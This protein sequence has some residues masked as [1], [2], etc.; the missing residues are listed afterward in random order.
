M[1]REIFERSL[2]WVRFFVGNGTQREL[3]LAGIGESTIHPE[4]PLFVRLARE[5]V[6]PA[7]KIIFATNGIDHNEEMVKAIA[8]YRPQVFVSLHRP[9]KAGRAIE[10]YKKYDLLVGVSADPSINGNTWAGQV[11]WVES[12]QKMRCQW[13][14]DGKAMVMSDGRITSCCLDSSGAGVVGNVSDPIGSAM[15]R[16]YKLCVGCYQTIDNPAWDQKAGVAK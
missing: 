5:A 6:G 7:I 14:Q 3:N 10:M 8:P 1:T 12:G 15:S 11:D 4:F 2:A 9:E 16:P 13:L